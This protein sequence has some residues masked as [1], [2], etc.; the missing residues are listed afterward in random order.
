MRRDRWDRTEKVYAAIMYSTE[1]LA[2]IS[3]TAFAFTREFAYGLIAV[4]ATVATAACHLMLLVYH[5]TRVILE[6]FRSTAGNEAQPAENPQPTG[7]AQAKPAFPLIK[8]VWALLD[9]GLDGEEVVNVTKYCESMGLLPANSSEKVGY[10][11]NAAS[12]ARLGGLNLEEFMLII[13]GAAKASGLK[14]EMKEL[15]EAA[16]SLLRKFLGKSFKQ[17]EYST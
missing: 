17:P 11:L 15:E 12:K 7:E 8:W 9:A 10:I 1:I 14:L 2:V 13:Y 4:I 5:R 6:G 3:I 16:F